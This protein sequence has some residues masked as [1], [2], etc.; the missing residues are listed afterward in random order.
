MTIEELIERLQKIKNK[1]SQIVTDTPSSGSLLY[2]K[3][4]DIRIDESKG[5]TIIEWVCE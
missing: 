4:R 2:R 1:K 3:I 5:F